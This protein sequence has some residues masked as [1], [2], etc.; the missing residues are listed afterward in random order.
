[1]LKGNQAKPNVIRYDLS[2]PSTSFAVH[3]QQVSTLLEIWRQYREE[4]TTDSPLPYRQLAEPPELRQRL[5]QEIIFFVDYLKTKSKHDC[6]G[7]DKNGDILRYVE[8][9]AVRSGRS[10]RCDSSETGSCVSVG[11]RPL[12]A[13]D[14]QNGRESPLRLLTPGSQDGRYKFLAL[15]ALQ[16][17]SPIYRIAGNFCG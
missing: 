2:C 1:M 4:Q 10:S 5:V 11:S 6:V 15:L 8:S 9:E 14:S 7:Q 12:S 16:S 13:V 17:I 3:P